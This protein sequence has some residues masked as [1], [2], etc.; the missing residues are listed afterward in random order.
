MAQSLTGKL[1][2][3]RN[4]ALAL[5]LAAAALAAILLAVY[6]TQYRDSVTS[7]SAPRQVLVAKRLIAKGTPGSTIGAKQLYQ[8]VTVP[9]AD[10]KVGALV[11]PALLNG[12]VTVADVYPGQ[13]LAETDFLSGGVA[14]GLAGALAGPHRAVSIS[15][16][17]LAGSLANLQTGDKVDIYQQIQGTNG[18]VIKLFRANV[19]ILYAPGAAGGTVV[20]S[21]PTRDVADT[22]YA[23]QHT[24]L[25]F[26]LRPANNAAPTV[27]RV[28]NTQSM[29]EYT[30]TH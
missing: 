2:A 13:Q 17:P 6:I 19:P 1:T 28:A 24:T 5:G 15:I 21:V 20:L 11:D 8:L 3:S 9:I 26:A 7:D 12:R 29:L 25:Q 16:D 22:L 27:P 18:T 10:V 23:S 4:G 14:T 30:R